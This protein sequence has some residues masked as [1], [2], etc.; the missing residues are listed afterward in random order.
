MTEMTDHRSLSLES[1]KNAGSDAIRTHDLFDVGAVLY[2]LIEL[3][4]Q[5]GAGQIV[6]FAIYL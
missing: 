1:L 2:Q 5:L 6:N 3:S 4:N